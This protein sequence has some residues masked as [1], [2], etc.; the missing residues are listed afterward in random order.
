MH[1]CAGI[2]SMRY[3]EKAGIAYIAATKR[4]NCAQS[5]DEKLTWQEEITTFKIGKITPLLRRENYLFLE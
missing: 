4:T 3:E 5:R 1:N 2:L